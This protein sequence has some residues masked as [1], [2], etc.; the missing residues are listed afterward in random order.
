MEIK[1]SKKSSKSKKTK[2]TQHTGF[3]KLR[4]EWLE[5][6]LI[7]LVL[8]V[9]IKIFIVQN[10]KIPS[11]SM[12]DTLLVGDRLFAVKF[13]YGAK[14]PFINHRIFK[15]RDPKPGDIIVFKFPEDPS[16]SYIKRCIAVGGQTFEIRDKKVYVDGE[17]QK[18]PEHAK[19]IDRNIL[20]DKRDNYG[21]ITVPEGN[22]FM[23]GDNRDNSRDSRYWGFLPYENL[24]GKAL[25]IYWS[26]DPDVEIYD[27]FHKV[28][29]RRIFNLIR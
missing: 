21:P 5:P 6:I 26:T 15:I 28:R 12:E 27:I 4:K 13:I 3:K 23:M 2:I 17:L 14:I 20:D 11:G 8:V 22:F 16:L 19:F 25:F 9:I 18:L 1:N 29:W 10:F 7:A 24:M